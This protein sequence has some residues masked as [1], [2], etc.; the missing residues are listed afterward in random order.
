MIEIEKCNS[1]D[2]N[3]FW[4]YINN[5]GPRKCTHIPWEVET[6]QGTS[7]DD[8]IVL[9]KWENAFES[10]FTSMNVLHDDEIK[11]QLLNEPLVEMINRELNVPVTIQEV[12][13]A[14]YGSKN[15]KAVGCDMIPNE[16]LKDKRVVKLLHKLFTE[17]LNSCKIPSAW[18][19][20][21]INPI[22]KE[23]GRV[24][25]PLKY[26]GIA[27]QCCVY[28]ILSRI[29]NDRVIMHLEQGDML[30]SV[31]NGFRGSRSCQHHIFSLV[32]LVKQETRAGRM[33]FSAFVDFKKA[34]DL[35]DRDLLFQQL[36]KL[37]INGNILGLIKQMYT[38]TVN[39]VKINNRF[40]PEFKSY[41]GV[42][43]GNNQLPTYFNCYIDTL[44]DELNSSAGGI[45]IGENR[46]INALAYADDIVLLANS[47]SSLQHLIDIV[48]KWCKIWR[49]T[50]NT[51][52]TKVMEFRWKGVQNS[53]GKYYYNEERLE[54]VSSYKYLGMII[55]YVCL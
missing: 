43:Q 42:P 51:S 50:V 53:G 36:C 10:L 6:D 27:L 46:V 22:P 7:C 33:V 13:E 1:S 15:R 40:T 26:R 14:V 52:K 12:R 38:D 5:L 28:K 47:H 30:N 35:V 54:L 17:C 25:D 18:R 9:K 19:R 29:I 32:N 24:L 48:A 41:Q 34:F 3:S 20:S 37:N 23:T 45:K 8:T 55:D 21:V 39:M 2:P 16:L 11:M 44:L 4:S 49:V 31:Q